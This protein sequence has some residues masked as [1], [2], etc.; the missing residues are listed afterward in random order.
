MNAVFRR[1]VGCTKHSSAMCGAGRS[2]AVSQLTSSTLAPAKAQD[3]EI[4]LD[5]I[6]QIISTI[7]GI[8]LLLGLDNLAD[9]FDLFGGGGA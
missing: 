2:I 7:R 5:L 4:I 9:L 1:N 8:L 3:L 6:N